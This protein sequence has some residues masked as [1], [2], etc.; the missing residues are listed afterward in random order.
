MLN[1]PTIKTKEKGEE[2]EGKR[3]REQREEGK[4]IT[5]YHNY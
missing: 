1:P 4:A 2:Q 3:S 5:I